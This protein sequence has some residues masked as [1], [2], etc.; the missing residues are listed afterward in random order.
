LQVKHGR[1]NNKPIGRSATGGAIAAPAFAYYYEKLLELYPET[2]RAF[3]IPQGVFRGEYDGKS[4]LYTE[5]SPFPI[6]KQ[7]VQDEYNNLSTGINV[8]EDEYGVI[9]M[10]DE[11]ISPEED[12]GLAETV[13]IDDEQN[14][15]IDYD[16]PLQL[17]RTAPEEPDSKDSGTM[18]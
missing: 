1:D 4:E 16:D 18:F 3:D 2:K 7:T 12:I 9:T 13:N 8:H 6:I 14:D 5:Q 15:Y 11:D 10:D 17:K